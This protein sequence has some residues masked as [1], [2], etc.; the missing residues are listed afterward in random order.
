VPA[1][2][3]VTTP[4]ADTVATVGLL[5][6]HVLPVGNAPNVVV[7]PTHTDAVPVILSGK[8]NTVAIW[9]LIQP[10]PSVNLKVIID[11]PALTPVNTPVV[12]LIIALS[13]LELVHVPPGTGSTVYSVFD[14]PTHKL[15]DPDM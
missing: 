1:L 15:N 14:A 6:L 12:G 13:V 2:T 8:A 3:P 7:D 11:V 5:L 4:V 10:K 9:V